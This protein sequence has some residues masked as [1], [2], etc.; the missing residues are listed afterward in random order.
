MATQME[1]IKPGPSDLLEESEQRNLQKDSGTRFEALGFSGGN[2]DQ[3]GNVTPADDSAI[4]GGNF[5]TRFSNVTASQ[6]SGGVQG[7]QAPG[8]YPPPPTPIPMPAAPDSGDDGGV[9]GMGLIPMALGALDRFCY[10]GG[11]PVMMADGTWKPVHELELGD[12]V[13]LGGFVIGCGAAISADLYEYGGCYVSGSHA[14][15]ED[16]LWLRVRDSAKATHIHLEDIAI[17]YPIAT[18]NHVMVLPTHVASDMMETDNGTNENDEE[19]ILA[20]NCNDDL[21]KAVATFLESASL[22]GEAVLE[23]ERLPDGVPVVG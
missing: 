16:G 4:R 19:R 5:S 13:M 8:G 3:S 2:Q 11:T 15:Y 9:L 7:A 12:E 1:P 17:V 20:L 22:E 18:T 6:S 21:C 23:S 10:M 14:V